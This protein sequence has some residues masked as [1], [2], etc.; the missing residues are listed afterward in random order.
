MIRLPQVSSKM[1]AVDPKRGQRDAFLVERLFEC[2]RCR[3]LAVGFQQQL[4]RRSEHP[5][6]PVFPH[7]S[8]RPRWHP[9]QVADVFG[10]CI[11][12][13]MRSHISLMP[14]A[15]SFSNFSGGSRY[16][17]L[18]RVNSSMTASDS[19][20]AAGSHFCISHAAISACSAGGSAPMA[21]LISLALNGGML[22]GVTGWRQCPTWLHGSRN[23]GV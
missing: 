5:I 6:H 13:R 9:P 8:G 20:G 17:C 12:L 4:H 19:Q 10:D 1:A 21:S 11:S 2:L 3:M 15:S 16:S 18:R 7:T 14:F 22:T 23:S